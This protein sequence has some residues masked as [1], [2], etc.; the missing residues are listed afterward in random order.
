[1]PPLNIEKRSYFINMQM[2]DFISLL[3]LKSTVGDEFNE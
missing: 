2:K 1:M 3:F